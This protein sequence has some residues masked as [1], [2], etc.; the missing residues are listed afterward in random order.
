MVLT[1]FMKFKNILF[2]FKRNKMEYILL[3]FYVLFYAKYALFCISYKTKLFLKKN[4]R[5]PKT[6]QLLCLAQTIFQELAPLS[7]REYSK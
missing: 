2:F 4:I 3:N 5:F 7:L 1:F 6:S